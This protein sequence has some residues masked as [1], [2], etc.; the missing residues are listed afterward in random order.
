[1]VAK[2]GGENVNYLFIEQVP[3]TIVPTC[4]IVIDDDNDAIQRTGVQVWQWSL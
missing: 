3:N 2:P 4:L 1:M